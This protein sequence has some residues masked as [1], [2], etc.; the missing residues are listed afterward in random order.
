MAKLSAAQTKALT[1]VHELG[2][3]TARPN[4]RDSVA[5]YITSE[6]SKLKLNEDGYK[7][8]GLQV[9]SREEFVPATSDDTDLF[10][11]MLKKNTLMG[12]WRNSEEAWGELSLTE[13][14]ED[15]KTA[16]PINRAARRL[17]H[18]ALT[19]EFRKLFAMRPRKALKLTGA[20]G[21]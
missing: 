17:H 9:E 7:A 1:E 16:H 4:T 6:G 11:D 8:L 2:Y 10:R 15:I 5:K 20:K 19:R 14:Q 3:T 21:L 12:Q 18:K 13:I